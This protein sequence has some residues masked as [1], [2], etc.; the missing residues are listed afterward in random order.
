MAFAGSSH[1]LAAK[2]RNRKQGRS[3]GH[4]DR[5]IGR[6]AKQNR[7]QLHNLELEPVSLSSSSRIFSKVMKTTSSNQCRRFTRWRSE[8]MM[9]K[10]CG[11]GKGDVS[12]E[13]GR[14]RNWKG[15]KKVGRMLYRCEHRPTFPLSKRSRS[16][17]AA[18]SRICNISSSMCGSWGKL[19]RPRSSRLSTASRLV[20]EK[21]LFRPQR[22]TC[23]AVQHNGKIQMQF[24]A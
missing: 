15:K 8:A 19:S 17:V 3:R 12:P 23:T 16:L 4:L 10:I 22:T 14:P 18:T 20:W 24:D 1:G 2:R 13:A 6:D 5:K 21:K 9:D 11:Q 7:K